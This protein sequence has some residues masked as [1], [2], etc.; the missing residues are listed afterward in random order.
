[1]LNVQ[2]DSIIYGLQSF[3]GITNYWQRL[4]DGLVA[5]EDV[6]CEFLLPKRSYNQLA[7]EACRESRFIT[8]ACP[9]SISRYFPVIRSNCDVFH[10]SYYRGVRKCSGLRVVTAYDFTY[11]KYRAGLPRTVHSVQKRRALLG[12]DKIICISESTKRDCMDF[13]PS[14]YED[15]IVAIP[16]GVDF[17]FFNAS[18]VGAE[19]ANLDPVDEKVILF[20]GNRSGYKRFDLAVRALQMRRGYTLGVVGPPLSQDESQMLRH[21]LGDKWRYF[22]FVPWKDLP[23]LYASAHAFIF[24]SDYEGFGLP[25]LEALSAGCPVV[26]ASR[27]SFPEVA[28]SAGFFA[29]SQEAECYVDALDKLEAA[30]RGKVV[31][32]GFLQAKIF[33]WDRTISSTIETYLC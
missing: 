15:R 32:D 8:E 6:Q 13:L 30:E 2:L 1:M 14:F 33:S 5:S 10:T 18:A 28:G 7:T 31:Q 24:P 11:E 3:G 12:A 21:R 19:G 27:S 16:L 20:V 23:A 22:G 29:E 9:T 4:G 26:L 25:V 17:D